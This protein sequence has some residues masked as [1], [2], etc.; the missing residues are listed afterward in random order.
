MF[1]STNRTHTQCRNKGNL[2]N[3]VVCISKIQN[4]KYKIQ[5]ILRQVRQWDCHISTHAD[6]TSTRRAHL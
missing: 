3:T 1:N 6:S 5:N 4:T 2:M